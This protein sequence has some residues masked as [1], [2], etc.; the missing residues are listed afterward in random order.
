MKRASQLFNDEQTGRI[1]EAI[2]E[3][4]SHTSAE[5]AAVLATASGRYDRA[6]DM[7]GLWFGLVLASVAYLLVPN[8]Q[9]ASNS[10]GGTSPICKLIIVLGCMI[11]GFV[12]GAIVGNKIVWM[13]R[14]C[15][16]RREMKEEV[17]S[18]ARAVFFDNR[19]HRT[20]GGTGLLVYISLYERQAVLLADETVTEKLTQPVLDE[21][22]NELIAS[23]RE[24]NAEAAICQSIASAGQHLGSVLPRANDDVDE[25]PNLLVTL[26]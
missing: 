3:A 17:Q 5:I 1:N 16:P 2:V 25:L 10:W 13:R 7:V 9:E 12:G 26:D 4:E 15:T 20:T 6:E 24:G 8:A 18:R 14:L 19:I 21:L 23:L 22:C 11:A